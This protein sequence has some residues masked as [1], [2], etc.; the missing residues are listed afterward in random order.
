MPITNSFKNC[1]TCLKNKLLTFA[2]FLFRCH[3]YTKCTDIKHIL[4]HTFAHVAYW[5]AGCFTLIVFL[6]SCDC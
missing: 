6:M 1:M 5:F 2:C 3:N 4:T